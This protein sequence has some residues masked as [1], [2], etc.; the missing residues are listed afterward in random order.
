M[1]EYD[2]FIGIRER[3]YKLWRI[4]VGIHDFLE[5]II[6]RGYGNVIMCANDDSPLLAASVHIVYGEAFSLLGS[7]GDRNV[8]EGVDFNGVT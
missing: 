7:Q 8:V 4:E 5:E 3:G 6:V 2:D 1:T